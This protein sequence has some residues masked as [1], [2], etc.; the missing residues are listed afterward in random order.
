MHLEIY[1]DGGSRGNPG[2]AGGGG[3]IKDFDSKQDLAHLSFWLGR[4]TN[5][6]A[7]YQAL[8]KT[9]EVA[10]KFQPQ[11]LTCYLDSQLVVYQLIGRYRVKNKDIKPLYE[12]VQTL[13]ADIKK[14]EFKHLYRQ[15]NAKADSLA[16]QAMDSQKSHQKL[17][18]S[19]DQKATTTQPHYFLLAVLSLDGRLNIEGFPITSWASLE[20][21]QVMIDKLNQADLIVVGHQT[22]KLAKARLKN[23]KCLIFRSQ[24]YEKIEALPKNPNHYYITPQYLDIDLYCKENKFKN[25]CLFGGRSVYQYFIEKNLVDTLFLTLEPVILGRGISLLEI[26]SLGPAFPRFELHSSKQLNK[27]GTLFLHYT[28]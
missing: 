17:L 19:P 4:T 20:D 23:K 24:G 10:K 8:I 15:D 9:L 26:D 1:T 12:Q 2:P 27:Q 3:V 14:I 7:E 21:R 25:I 22:Y 13:I 6:Q 16:N 28:K 18:K 11:A 5:N